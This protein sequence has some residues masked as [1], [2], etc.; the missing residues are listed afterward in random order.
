MLE[1]GLIGI[2]NAGKSEL[3]NHLIGQKFSAVSSKKN[4]TVKA[5]LG[6]FVSK[7]N[8]QI[9]LHDLP[10]VLRHKD[11][12]NKL[13]LA[14]VDKAWSMAVHCDVVTFIVDAAQV[15]K[16]L[17][18]GNS[19]QLDP[20][21]MKAMPVFDLAVQLQHGKQNESYSEIILALNK[22]DLV[23]ETEQFKLTVVED[24]LRERCDFSRSFFISALH[25]QG[26]SELRS[27]L[28]SLAKEGDW[29][30]P[31][32][33]C[34]DKSLGE[35]A[36]EFVR[37]KLFKRLNQDIPYKLQIEL[38]SEDVMDSGGIHFE[39]VIRVRDQHIKKIVVGHQG[40]V[41]HSYVTARARWELEKLLKRKVFLSVNVKSDR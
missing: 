13:Q 18:K 26:I 9:V 27:Y 5:H 4:T 11:V 7:G 24:I 6:A 17:L 21:M 29:V 1:V 3:A 14:R 31:K 8:T 22:V 32:G 2:P 12:K 36:V 34:T 10:G 28:H 38:A 35:L 39:I 40:K 15:I 23:T 41:I 30:L 20:Q 19:G 33:A 37:E 25:G 16:N